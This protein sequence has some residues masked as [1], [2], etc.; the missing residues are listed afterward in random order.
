MRLWYLSHRLVN[1]GPVNPFKPNGIAHSY[2]LDQF[3][4]ILRVAG[5]YFSILFKF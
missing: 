4:S 1:I 3:I 5:W 2:Q